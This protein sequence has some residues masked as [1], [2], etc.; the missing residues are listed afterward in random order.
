MKKFTGY[1]NFL[2]LLLFFNFLP[3]FAVAQQKVDTHVSG[4]ILDEKQEPLPFAA[5][6]LKAKND[7]TVIK[8]AL[9]EVNGKFMLPNVPVGVFILEITML[10]YETYRKEI[11]SVAVDTDNELGNIQ[12]KPAAKNLSAI[13]ISGQKP[14]IEQRADKIVVNLNDQLTGGSS[15]MEV[16]DRMP[17]VQVNPDN[18]VYLNGRNVR[19]YI[20]GKPTPL[21]ADALAGLL[22]GM[23]AT[24]IERVELIARPSSKYDASAS[25]GIINIVRKRGTR[26]GLRGNVY[27]GGGFGR[28][29]KYTGGFNLNFKTGKYN[30]LL[31]TDYNFNKYFVDNDIL[32]TPTGKPGIVSGGSESLIKSVRQMNNI[33]PNI[34][35][36]L[37]LTKK[38]TLSF[39]VTNAL[40]L[41]K[42][43]AFSE[44]RDL[45]KENQA[46]NFD[47]RVNTRM[48]NFSSGLHL[49]HQ[50][51][52]L[53]KELTVDLDYYRNVNYSDQRNTER[54]FRQAGDALRRTFF[55]QNN[56]F[57]VYSAKADLTLPLKHKA[58]METGF[59]SS[60]VETDNRNLLYDMNGGKM[61]PND[62]QSDLYR[63]SE[64]IHALYTT[65]HQELKKLSYQLGLRA[66]GT[67]NSGRQLQSNQRFSQNYVQLFP[68]VFFDYKVTDKHSF[69][70]SFDKKTNRPAY[71]N[72]NPLLRIINANNFVQG[73]PNLRSVSSYNGSATLSYR[74][75]LFV[76]A[77]YGI[78]FR[79]FTYFAFQNQIGDSTVTRPVNNRYTQTLSLITAYNSQ[80]KPWWYT[81]SNINLRKLSYQLVDEHV[82]MTGI[83][84][85]NFDTYNSFSLTKQLSWLI[86]FRFRGKSQERNIKTDAYF[87]LTS[88]LRQSLLKKRATIA[89]NVTDIFNTF[90]NRYLQQSLALRQVW[91]NRYETTTIR[92]N[93][94]YN[95][96]GQINKIKKSNASTDEKR[97]IDT[98]E[99]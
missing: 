95:F 72:M 26:E 79:D 34:G 20:D 58:Q 46:G 31:N 93:F 14:F 17:G 55:D 49:L 63:Y 9:S 39:A 66:E 38:T 42:K 78:D 28:Y 8:T 71:E 88:G 56:A 61:I 41:F 37:Y 25:G 69:I 1:F 33:T 97:R 40:Q 94:T 53:G 50:M 54:I 30:L 5:I 85:F 16:M 64:S 3:G 59:K 87:T 18:M 22:R 96:G 76:T 21:S 4:V 15:L 29:A 62:S 73:N 7:S 45:D 68:T 48:N 52:T 43:N 99:N 60:Y 75:A 77:N 74:N 35:L 91:E 6:V 83:T 51:D 36:D 84:T 12:L 81:S 11:E 89:L 24:S 32:A 92:L 90:K 23:S 80:I 82:K 44:T 13:T 57:N 70:F 19:I 27:G 47:N 67:W 98:K 86:L 10:G 65:F 2:V